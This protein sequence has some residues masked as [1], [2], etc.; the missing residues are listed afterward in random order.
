MGIR[1]GLLFLPQRCLNCL[2]NA[3]QVREIAVF[4]NSFVAD[5][6]VPLITEK[7]GQQLAV[8]PAFVW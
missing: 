3:L 6:V 2:D 4:L 1:Y 5:W 8:M 7:L